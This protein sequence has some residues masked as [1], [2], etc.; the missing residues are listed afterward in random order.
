MSGRIEKYVGGVGASPCLRHGPFETQ[1]KLLGTRGVL[2]EFPAGERAVENFAET[3]GRT[4]SIQITEPH[5]PTLEAALD[6]R[7]LKQGDHSA[8]TRITFDFALERNHSLLFSFEHLHEIAV[9]IQ[10][11][12]R[13]AQFRIIG[14]AFF[15]EFVEF[16]LGKR[17]S[18]GT[19]VDD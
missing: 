19:D 6:D 16:R 14:P 15:Q 18:R 4:G 9:F 13:H 3:L 11:H 2:L 7:L 1:Q 12:T 17:I 5:R 10:Q 8:V